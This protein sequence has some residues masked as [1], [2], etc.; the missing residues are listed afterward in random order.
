[1]DDPD[2]IDAFVSGGG[3]KAF[4]PAL[5]IE[6]DALLLSG[7]WQAAFRVTPEVFMLRNEDPPEEAQV[8]QNVAGAL[9]ERGLTE[10]GADLPAMT[11]IIYAELTLGDV[12]WT[13]WA[14]DRVTGEQALRARATVES[15]FGDAPSAP[16]ELADFGAELGGARR[17]AGLPPTLVLTIGLQPDL[18]EQLEA[19]L[20]ECRFVSKSFDQIAVDACS[21][22]I[23]TMIVIDASERVGQDFIADLRY[24]PFCRFLPVAAVIGAADLS[25]P[26]DVFLDPALPPG[27]WADRLRRVL[28]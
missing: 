10:V 17:I 13:L 14:A 19:S 7:W 6:G 28:P 21:A 18:A 11:A 8:V 25:T 26:V 1:M 23:P 2:V 22:L 3:R 16:A 15:F 9:V 4:G 24:D 27:A 12:S 5:H 20:A